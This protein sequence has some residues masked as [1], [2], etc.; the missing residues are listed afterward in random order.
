MKQPNVPGLAFALVAVALAVHF[1]PID[2]ALLYYGAVE[3]ASGEDWRY[4]SGHLVHADG[5][6][7]LWNILGLLILGILVERRSRRLMALSLL[8]GIVSVD[9]L[10]LASGLDY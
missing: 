1:L 7:L 6:H 9:A 5:N 10:L 2:P 8:A 4:V 3:I